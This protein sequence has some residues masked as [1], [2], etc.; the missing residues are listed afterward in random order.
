[1]AGICADVVTRVNVILYAGACLNAPAT[2][3][4]VLKVLAT[5]LI[6]LENSSCGLTTAPSLNRVTGGPDL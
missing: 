1:M 2:S 3:P 6:I 5:L 4:V